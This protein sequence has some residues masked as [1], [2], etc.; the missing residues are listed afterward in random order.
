MGEREMQSEERHQTLQSPLSP[1]S[2]PCPPCLCGLILR[3][4]VLQHAANQ[5]PQ[6]RLRGVRRGD[7]LLDVGRLG[8]V[9]KAHVGDDRQAERCAGRSGR[10]RSLRGRSTC[11]RRRRRSAAGS[12]TRPAFPGSGP[13]T[14]TVTPRW[15]TKFCCRAISRPASISSRIVGRRHVGEPRAEPVVVDAHQR[16][17]AHEVDVVV[18]DH[19]VAGA[20]VRV[21]AADGLRDDEQLRAEPLH[22][23]HRQRDLLERVAFVLMEAAFHRHDGHA[24]EPAADE[25]AAVAGGRRLREV[26]ESL[27]SRASAATSICST[28]PPRPVPRMMPACGVSGHAAE[29]RRRLLRFGRRVRAS[30]YLEKLY[31]HRDTEGTERWNGER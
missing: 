2:P 27:R 6:L 9:G 11:R 5:R 1:R 10:R 24:F 4:I 15:A 18:D 13:V 26:R 25:P 31:C 14:A 3:R 8:A 28:R 22:H 19:H 16:V 29:W 23:A 17:V 30:D 7:D 21:H 20:V 12:G